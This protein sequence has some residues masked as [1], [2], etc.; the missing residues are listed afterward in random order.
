MRSEHWISKKL[1]VLPLNSD[2]HQ[3]ACN[4]F[5]CAHI[6]NCFGGDGDTTLWIDIDEKNF[7]SFTCRIVYCPIEFESMSSTSM[8]SQNKSLS[9]KCF[10]LLLLSP[11]TLFDLMEGFFSCLC[12]KRRFKR[13]NQNMVR[14]GQSSTKK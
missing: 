13:E 2:K 11:N 8:K 4:D 10:L 7:Y 14:K 3:V 12:V 5:A 9:Q 6:Q 1:T